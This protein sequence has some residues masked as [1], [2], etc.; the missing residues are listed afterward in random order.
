MRI[1]ARKRKNRSYI[2]KGLLLRSE[3]TEDNNQKKTSRANPALS[4]N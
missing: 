1:N 4:K 3:W 2:S